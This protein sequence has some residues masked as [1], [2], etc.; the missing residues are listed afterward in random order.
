MP[1]AEN[2]ESP[3]VAVAR[4]GPS[5]RYAA[6]MAYDAATGSSI[7]FGGIE[8]GLEWR[9]MVLERQRLDAGGDHRAKGEARHAMAYDVG[10]GRVLL[11]GGF[12][13]S[14][15][16]NDIWEWDGSAGLRGGPGRSSSSV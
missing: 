2:L 11:F 3:H 8:A 4:T 1:R 12:G 5:A 14:P 15:L 9:D 13:A 7:L 10:R 16:K 6:A